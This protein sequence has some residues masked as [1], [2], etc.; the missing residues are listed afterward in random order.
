MAEKIQTF[1]VVAQGG[2]DSFHRTAKI[3]HKR[4]LNLL[5]GGFY[6]LYDLSVVKLVPHNS[7]IAAVVRA[8]EKTVKRMTPQ[9]EID[10]DDAIALVQTVEKLNKKPQTCRTPRSNR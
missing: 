9:L 2:V 3:A 4:M 5:V 10:V 6:E 1:C 8:A 7:K